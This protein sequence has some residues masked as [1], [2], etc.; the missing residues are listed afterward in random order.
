MIHD[1]TFCPSETH[2]DS[3]C[4]KAM[5]RIKMKVS[6]IR[7]SLGYS[8]YLERRLSCKQHWRAK[9]R[10]G[11]K[12]SAGTSQH[13]IF[14]FPELRGLSCLAWSMNSSMMS[15]IPGHLASSWRTPGTEPHF[16]VLVFF[17]MSR[18]QSW[19][20]M[21]LHLFSVIKLNC[22]LYPRLVRS[23]WVNSTMA[24]PIPY[25]NINYLRVGI[26]SYLSSCFHPFPTQL[27][28]FYKEGF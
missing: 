15:L 7:L 19:K 23:L 22:A 3:E 25:W 16:D 12:N 1:F 24:H 2:S 27:W 20:P 5:T 4:I 21:P 26:K 8:L 6:A 10:T 14:K 18:T 9:K 11:I 17:W 13:G 28:S